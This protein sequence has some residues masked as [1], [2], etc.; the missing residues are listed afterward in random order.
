MLTTESTSSALS[1]ASVHSDRETAMETLALA[2]RGIHMANAANV[3]CRIILGKQLLAIQE[4]QLWR[5]DGHRTWDKW[6]HVKFTELTKF[7][8][9]TAYGAMQLARCEALSSM[10]ESELQTFSTLSNAIRLARLER[11]NNGTPI[12]PAMIEA[13]RTLPS[14]AFRLMAGHDEAGSVEAE[15]VTTQGAQHLTA[16]VDLLKSA[17]DGALEHLRQLVE[18]AFAAAGGS[19]TDLA[20]ALS[21]AIQSELEAQDEAP[22]KISS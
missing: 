1:L 18:L 22:P 19:P 12:S 3:F 17:D 8:G 13:A 6:L 16:I 14:Q 20:D 5:D 4:H 7:S 9:E 10:T 2:A 21:A 15:T 11:N